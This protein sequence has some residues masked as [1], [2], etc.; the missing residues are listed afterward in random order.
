MELAPF[1]QL[2]WLLGVI[3]PFPRPLWIRDYAINFNI[4]DNMMLQ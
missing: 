2:H 4:D 1:V 3:G